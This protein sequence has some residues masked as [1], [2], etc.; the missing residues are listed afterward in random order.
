MA[1]EIP[2]KTGDAKGKHHEAAVNSGVGGGEVMQEKQN[3]FLS[4]PEDV[5]E[6]SS[7]G[8]KL[9]CSAFAAASRTTLLREGRGAERAR[10]FY[11][12]R[13][14]K[15]LQEIIRK[16]PDSLKVFSEFQRKSDHASRRL[17]KRE[18]ERRLLLS[19]SL[20]SFPFVEF[21]I[22]R[23]IELSFGLRNRRPET[24]E[25]QKKIE[26]RVKRKA[27]QL[28]PQKSLRKSEKWCS[29]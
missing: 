25:E 12:I 17:K 14:L 9:C 26:K 23:E 28:R 13:P 16:R 4:S 5:L 10:V 29:R 1:N 6:R 24:K 18:R 27:R 3:S 20:F 11:N 15:E 7:G 21:Y 22:W 8:R 2:P 19:F